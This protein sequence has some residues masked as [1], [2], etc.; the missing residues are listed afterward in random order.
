LQAERLAAVVP[1]SQ[2]A[3][4]R[5][6]PAAVGGLRADAVGRLTDRRLGGKNEWRTRYKR[7]A[8]VGSEAAPRRC[9]GDGGKG[10]E[11]AQPEGRVGS[12]RASPTIRR[13]CPTTARGLRAEACRTHLADSRE[14]GM[15]SGRGCVRWETMPDV[16]RLPLLMKR[17]NILLC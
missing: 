14:E 10:G 1:N 15:A 16:N 11:A 17:Q 5:G 2:R 13:G 9:E 7:A 8:R 4:Q 3:E 12:S 6:I